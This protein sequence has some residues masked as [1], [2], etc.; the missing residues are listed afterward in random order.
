MFPCHESAL[1]TLCYSDIFDYPLTRSEIENYQIGT[2][3]IP[4]SPKYVEKKGIYYFLKGRKKIVEW[5]KKREMWSNQKLERSGRLARFLT[6]I[7]TVKL[8]AVTGAVAAGNARQD[9]DI[10]LMIVTSRGWIWTTRFLTIL[11]A[12]ILGVRR[13]P[14]SS[15]L[16]DML[17]FN[18][19]MDE[20]HVSVP[21]NER[22]LFSANE[23]VR[24][25][26]LWGK[27]ETIAR[28]WRTNRWIKEFLPNYKLPIRNS[29]KELYTNYDSRI[30]E[31]LFRW[32][33]LR[34]MRRRRTS[35]VISDGYLRFHP[36][37]ARTWIL[38]A[39][40]ARLKK[41]GINDII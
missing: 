13:R 28:F 6:L 41:Y 30:L 16:K 35:E 3:K 36:R 22:D 29:E 19:F 31:K 14:H 34:Y 11:L 23:V 8:I 26:I 25:K 2:N 32:L 24:V 20:D 18:M 9:D 5:R 38:T 21:S 33:Q 37:D 1:R 10:D 40:R 7:P 39:Y 17:C 4:I 12:E 15:D 27:K